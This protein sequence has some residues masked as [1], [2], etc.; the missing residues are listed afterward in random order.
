MAD[1]RER[2]GTELSPVS[3]CEQ[4]SVGLASDP[5][6]SATG[7]DASHANSPPVG[8]GSLETRL[9]VQAPNATAGGSLGP[10]AAE[11]AADRTVCR[12]AD[13]RREV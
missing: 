7:S 10:S 5:R 2:T 13:H 12:S 1:R 3:C 9:L 8:A 4:L 11:R 6:R